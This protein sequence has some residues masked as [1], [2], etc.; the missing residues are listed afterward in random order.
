MSFH[1]DLG[2]GKLH[3]VEQVR[4]AQLQGRVRRSQSIQENDHVSCARHSLFEELDPLP[5]KCRREGERQSGQV[6]ARMGDAF[7]ET[8]VHRVGHPD[9]HDRDARR[10]LLGRLGAYSRRLDDHVDF[11]SEQIAEQLGETLDVPVCPSFLHEDVLPLD[12]TELA[13]TRAERVDEMLVGRA[14]PGFHETD[15]RDLRRCL[16]VRQPRSGDETPTR[17]GN[18]GSPVR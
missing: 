12:V 11:R 1:I 5:G 2:S 17:R 4:V 18:E 10:G 13:Q 6:F 16:G 3:R 8:E 14:R 9:E 15:L 7:D